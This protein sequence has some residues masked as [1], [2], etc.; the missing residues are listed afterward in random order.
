MSLPKHYHVLTEIK[1]LKEEF[2]AD[3]SHCM[4]IHLTTDLAAEVRKEL[5]DYYGRDLGEPMMTLFGAE[6]LSTD[7][8]EISFEE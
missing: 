1:R 3:G 8:P 7:A 4:G 2:E 6:V 5:H